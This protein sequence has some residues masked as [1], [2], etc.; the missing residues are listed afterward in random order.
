MEEEELR[1]EICKELAKISDRKQLLEAII[2]L[3]LFDMV[4][5]QENMDK[6]V[7]EYE[8]YRRATGDKNYEFA[9]DLEKV[10][11]KL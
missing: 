5:A 3:R 2:I 9:N 4:I 8:R 1:K 6:A 11:K 7:K 10:L